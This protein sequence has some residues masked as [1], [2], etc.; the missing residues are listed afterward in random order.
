M[1]INLKKEKHSKEKA[2]RFTDDD[3]ADINLDSIRKNERIFIPYDKL[4]DDE[5][6]IAAS[7]GDENLAI[8][9]EGC[10]YE[11]NKE[12]M[13]QIQLVLTRIDIPKDHNFSGYNA[14]LYGRQ[15][16]LREKYA[17]LNAEAAKKERKG[18]KPIKDRFKYFKKMLEDDAFEPAA[19]KEGKQ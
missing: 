7:Y 2:I 16:Y 4:P 5:E 15:H 11:F 13:E 3:F 14:T 9:A 10:G 12:Q 19:Y 17:A 8:L 6:R 18:S 1:A